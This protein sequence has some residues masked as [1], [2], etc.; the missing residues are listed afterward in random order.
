MQLEK[1]IEKYLTDRV[2]KAGGHCW[3]FTSPG[4]SGVPDRVLICKGQVIFAEIKKP[5]GVLSPI[6]KVRIDQIRNQGIQAEVI[7]SKQDVDQLM[8]QF[9]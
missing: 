1:E 4:R 2:R 9:E 3:K 8:R 7:W 6:Q 5:D